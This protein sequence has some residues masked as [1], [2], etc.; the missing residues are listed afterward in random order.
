MAALSPVFFGC[1]SKGEVYLDEERRYDLLLRQLEGCDIE[2][3]LRK[4]RRIRSGPQNRYLHGVVI[5]ILAEHIGY[6]LEEMKEALKW[7]FLQ[8]HQNGKL[9]TVRSTARLDT[10]EMTEFI[11]QT[12]R[13]AAEMGCYIPDPGEIE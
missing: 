3:L 10:A 12:R 2:L 8:V 7:R 4:R 13:L 11:E 5:P 9:P 1:V 6:D